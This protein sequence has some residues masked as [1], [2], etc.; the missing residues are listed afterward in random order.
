MP[1]KTKIA[2]CTDSWNPI[3]GCNKVSPGCARCYAEVIAERF[4][5]S[6]A[7]P[8]GF[9]LTYRPHLLE[10]PVKKTKPM[11]I[12]VNSM[13]D[14]F[15][16][17]IPL[18]Y[19]QKIFD[20]MHRSPQ[21]I[22]QILTKRPEIMRKYSVFDDSN[23]E[24]LLPESLLKWSSNIWA[25]TSVE[26]ADYLHRIDSLRGVPA[27]VR[28]LSIE[29]LLGP[30]DNMDLTGIDW[31]IVGGESGNGARPMQAYWAEQIREICEE[32]GVAFF[33]KQMGGRSKDKGGNELNGKVYEDYP[34][35][36]IYPPG[37]NPYE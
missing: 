37:L 23:I 6:A 10:W 33:F 24:S 18:D 1:G 28:F 13:S 14:C 27:A 8:N 31:V 35:S 22:F 12:F 3:S 32:Q 4:R 19:I 7:Y 26:N 16:K 20:V 25:G 30:V 11:M 21:H 15:H 34:K 29:P 5:G 9:D 36:A 2:W 17:D